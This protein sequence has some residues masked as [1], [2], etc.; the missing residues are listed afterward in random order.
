MP[1][2]I[3]NI[4]EGIEEIV[5]RMNISISQQSFP[6]NYLSFGGNIDPQIETLN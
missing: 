4:L 5:F 6:N 2:G 3:E 1:Q